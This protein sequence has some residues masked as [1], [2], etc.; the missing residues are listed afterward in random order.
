MTMSILIIK[1]MTLLTFYQSTFIVYSS[2][3]ICHKWQKFLKI[4]GQVKENWVE[5]KTGLQSNMEL[6]LGVFGRL[7]G[8]IMSC[9]NE[10][11]TGLQV[12]K[13]KKDLSEQKNHEGKRYRK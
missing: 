12:T 13:G 2:C 11:A 7:Y 10:M 1:S 6:R 8:F 9:S 3:K 4:F 5:L